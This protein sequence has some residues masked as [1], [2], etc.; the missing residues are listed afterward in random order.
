MDA[1]RAA[2]D[3]ACVH[4]EL[5][6]GERAFGVAHA[7][8]EHALRVVEDRAAYAGSPATFTIWSGSWSMSKK[9]GGNV[10][11]PEKCTYLP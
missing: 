3:E 9:I 8:G 11:W 1:L 4:G 2:L 6:A 10:G 7:P 5:H